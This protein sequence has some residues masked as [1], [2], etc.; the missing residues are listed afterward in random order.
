MSGHSKWATIKHQKAA[1]DKAR[2]KNFAKLIRQVEVAAR[3][4][5]GDQDS[6]PTLRTMFQK[7]RAASVPL[8]T[9]ERAVKRGTGELEG[10]NYEQISYEGYAPHGVAL[11]IEVLTD[12]RNRTGSEIRTLFTRN[13]GSMAEPGA[14]AWQFERKGVVDVDRSAEED[15]VM[16]AALEAGADDVDDVGDAWRVTTPPGDVEA[17]RAAIEAAGLPVQSSDATMVASNTVPL[18]DV[19]AAKSVLRLIDLIDEQ[20]DVQDVHANLDLSDEVAAALEA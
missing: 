14:V 4:G 8:D 11:Y 16:E 9:I 6:N 19:E 17:V 2:G 3:Q 13:G 1:K 7:A 5:G 10:V 12:N 20:D 15:A 18:D